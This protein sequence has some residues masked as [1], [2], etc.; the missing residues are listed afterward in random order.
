MEQPVLVFGAGGLGK[1][2]LEILQ[3]ND[4][5]VYGMLDDDPKLHGTS[6]GEVPVLGPTDEQGFLKLIGKKCQAFI[7]SDDKRLKRR[8]VKML[9]D[10]RKVMPM[11]AVHRHAY[12]SSLSSIGHGNLIGA[13]AVIN[14]HA[15]LGNHNVLHA[16]CTIDYGAG[17]KDYITIGAGT[18]IGA[19]VNIGDGVFVGA[20]A[21]LVSGI[22]IGANARI[23][24]GS[25]VVDNVSENE[26][27]FG[28]PAQK[29][30][31]R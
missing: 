18:T 6:I 28:N 29:V 3:S 14:C 22:A 16:N 9:N 17:L 1:V 4:I 5:M 8:L 20:G 13:G 12:L 23:G 11:N 10:Q 26:T 31:D 27:V 7:A 25:V 15:L 24:A 19:E 21:T 2:A 30:K